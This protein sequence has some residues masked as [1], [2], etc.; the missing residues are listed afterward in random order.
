MKSSVPLIPPYGGTLVDRTVDAGSL[1]RS[2]AM[3]APAIKLAH[4]A[5]IHL[6]NLAVGCY[7]PL[8]G[9]MTEEMYQSVIAD[10]LCAPG[11]NW[12]IPIL[13]HVETE[14]FAKVKPGDV[15]VLQN[16]NGVAVATLNVESA[17]SIAPD[18]YCKSVYGTTSKTHPG[19]QDLLGKPPTCLGGTVSVAM[20]IMPKFRYLSTPA[21]ARA[22]VEASQAAT[23]VAF[24]TRNICHLG[25]EYL[26]NTALESADALCISIITGA[27]VK[28]SFL[29]DVI[30]DTY[31]YLLGNHYPED[32]VL[33][34]NL[35]LPPIYGG[36]KEAFLQAT[37]MQN[38][39]FTDF[40]V[41][42]DHA[43]IGD[44]YSKYASQKIFEMLTSL[45]IEIRTISEPR[46][47]K[48]CNKIT[49]ERGCRHDGTDVRTLNGRD[50]R[51]YLMEN[52]F[53]ELDSILR[54]ELSNLLT[55]MFEENLTPGSTELC[56]RERRKLL[57]E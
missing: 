51:R 26:H 56:M 23:C 43:G 30:F 16:A 55:R 52:R 13:L 47:C 18:A 12:T 9:F 14:I 11:L 27:Q 7:S 21:V 4:D 20:E 5:A 49:T 15:L 3:G 41:G 24:S 32:R 37:M 48:V 57:Y 40:I 2:V 8:Q 31:E 39:G 38:Y 17:F 44:F 6:G 42:R 35:R 22:W 45:D 25:H 53:A 54:P 19:V 28:G 46:F 34:N 36:P 33:L 50:V 1:S 10:G 29:P